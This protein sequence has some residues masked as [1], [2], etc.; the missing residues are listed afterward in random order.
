MLFAK[1][2]QKFTLVILALLFVVAVFANTGIALAADTASLS[3]SP[4]TQNVSNGATV[5]AAIYVN[6]GS[7]IINTV[8]V[9]VNYPAANLQYSSVD[10]TGSP[11]EVHASETGG[12]GVVT[13]AV[14][15]TTPTSG[16]QL[17]ATLKFTALSTGSVSLGFGCN[18]NSSTCNDGNVVIRN[19][20]NT[21]ILWSSWNSLG[22]GFMSGPAATVD[23]SNHINVFS[24]GLD[25]ALWQRTYNGTSWSAWSSLGGGFNT[26]PAA[27]V[28]GSGNI[29]VFGVGLDKTIW[30]RTYNGTSWSA[31]SSLGGGFM[32]GPAATV[33]GS[34][35]DIYGVGLDKAAWQRTYSNGSWS[36]WSSLGGGFNTGP[37]AT[38]DST[39]ATN[40]FGVGTDKA[41]WDINQ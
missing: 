34:R 6:S 40:V 1:K 10:H 11:Y 31:W 20:D 8:G 36:N 13:I 16:N 17:V 14:G 28:D 15:T 4:T 30:Q 38:V 9:K 29:N 26:G 12:S 23:S 3:I 25:K 19:S 7:Q 27:T 37:A 35:I 5:S 2:T 33:S 22:G 21:N 41:I 39:G 24:V 18:Y 32:A